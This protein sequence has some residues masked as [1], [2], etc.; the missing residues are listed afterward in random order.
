M[1]D[2]I[3]VAPFLVALA[4]TARFL[5]TDGQTVPLDQPEALAPLA[6]SLAKR[7]L[8]VL[9]LAVA[10]AVFGAAYAEL[11]PAACHAHDCRRSAAGNC[12]HEICVLV[13][14]LSFWMRSTRE[15]CDFPGKIHS[16]VLLPLIWSSIKAI[17]FLFKV[18]N[19]GFGFYIM[20]IC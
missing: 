12:V 11:G 19:L 16:K 5:W 1:R 3:E 15:I 10:A 8:N 4:A 20:H 6:L 13:D 7:R 17:I 14:A 2:P 9:G 18:H